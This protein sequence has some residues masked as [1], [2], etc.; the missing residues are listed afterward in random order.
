MAKK[1][2]TKNKETLYGII[3][4]GRFGFALAQSLAEAGK[5]ILVIDRDQGKINA[6]A[7]FTDNAFCIDNLT[8]ENLETV[9]LADCDI[10]VIAIGEQID[11]SIL[12]TLTVLRLGVGRVIARP[13]VGDAVAFVH[14]ALKEN[15]TILL[16]GQLGSMKDPD[17]GIFPMTTSSHTLA[18]FGCVGAAVPPTAVKDVICVSKA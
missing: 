10:V 18:G 1:K 6:A 14:Q 4:L 15:K 17:L 2:N 8:R 16:E 9:G 7:A 13:Y 12:T 3:G 11:T 5:E